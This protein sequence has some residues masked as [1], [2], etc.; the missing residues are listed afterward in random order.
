MSIHVVHLIDS[1]GMFGAE[2]VVF[3]LLIALKELDFDVILGCLSPTHL[4]GADLGRELAKR[5]I[6]VVFL[7]EQKRISLRGLIAIYRLL[8]RSHADI[9]HVNGYKA[10]V[11]GGIVSSIIGI[12]YIATYHGEAAQDL[13][14]LSKYSRV[15]LIFLNRT[16]RII[17]VSN[18]IK[19]ELT[20]RGVAVEKISVIHNGIEDPMELNVQPDNKIGYKRRYPHI[21]CVGRLVPLKRFDLVIDA[22]NTLRKEYPE[23]LLSIA[24]TGPMEETLKAKVSSLGINEAV[25]FLGYVENTRQL[26]KSADIFVLF[27]EMEG[28]PIVLIE[29]MAYSLPIITTAVGGIPEMLNN[30]NAIILPSG[31]VSKLVVS[32]RQLTSNLEYAKDLGRAAR[33]N[34]VSR[35][36]SN[37]MVNK[38][39]KQYNEI[40]NKKEIN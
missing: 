28:S 27:S 31:D 21:L 11:L 34:F 8:K 6:P 37:I 10:T 39:V 9:L 18:R 25:Q 2:H 17:A 24:G 40:V 16:A 26:Y 19:N 12:P 33:N 30:E 22:I 4:P 38:Y 5:Q 23:I 20:T 35:F 32:V 36:K 15:E 1:E 7:N 13:K 14:L 3:N 29:A